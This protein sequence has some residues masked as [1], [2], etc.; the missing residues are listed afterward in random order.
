M[1]KKTKVLKLIKIPKD[2]IV[3][4]LLRNGVDIDDLSQPELKPINVRVE[5]KG[6]LVEITHTTSDPIVVSTNAPF[7]FILKAIFDE[8]P[9]IEE[10]YPPGSLSIA[11]NDLP[12]TDFD[13]LHE[14]DVITLGP[15]RKLIN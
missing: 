7:V 14:G 3:N 5:Y 2:Q 9:K 11:V 12:P 10:L 13:T 8:H 1:T 6:A 15:Y 4:E